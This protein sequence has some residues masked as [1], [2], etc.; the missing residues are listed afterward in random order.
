MVRIFGT[1]KE[2]WEDV[3]REYNACWLPLEVVPSDRRTL[4]ISRP[5]SLEGTDVFGMATEGT[6]DGCA[7]PTK[8]REEQLRS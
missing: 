4:G 8:E 3:T 7:V 6:F 1:D 2:R 5:I